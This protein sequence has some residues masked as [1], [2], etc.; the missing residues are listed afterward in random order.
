VRIYNVFGTYMFEGGGSSGGV[1]DGAQGGNFL[2]SNTGAG[3]FGTQIPGSGASNGDDA[4]AGVLLHVNYAHMFFPN[5]QQ[6]NQSNNIGI[7]GG[8]F[9]GFPPGGFGYGF[10][11]Y[12]GKTY[13]GNGGSGL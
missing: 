4:P 7:N 3:G 5:Q 1:G 6:I 8:G 12:G 2:G 9:Q 11:P 10:P 13:F